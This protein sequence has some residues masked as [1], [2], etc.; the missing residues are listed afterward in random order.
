MLGMARYTEMFQKRVKGKGAPRVPPGGLRALHMGLRVSP[1]GLT[2]LCWCCCP[3]F[4][5]A[6]N[7]V[8]KQVSEEV[9]QA[10]K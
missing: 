10:S 4:A 2:G 9:K 6:S 8:S 1:E 5:A 3:Q 7:Q